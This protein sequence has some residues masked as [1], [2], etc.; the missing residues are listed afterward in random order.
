MALQPNSFNGQDKLQ[1]GAR[2]ETFQANLPGYRDQD[3][4]INRTNNKLATNAHDVPNV[5]YEF[6]RRLPVLFRYGFAYGYNQIVIPKGRLV[7]ADPNM[8][9]LDFDMRHANNTLTLANGG[10][11][12]RL[13]TTGDLYRGGDGASAL[14]STEKQGLAVLNADKDWIPLTGMTSAYSKISFK[15]FHTDG[16]TNQLKKAGYG[17]DA[18]TGKVVP[19][20][21]AADEIATGV[22]AVVAGANVTVR[23]GNVPLGVLSR[24][25][26]TRDDDAYNGMM[27]GA[28]MTDAMIDLPW[29]AYKDKA[30]QNPWG[31]AYGGLFPGA[32]IKSDEN[33]RFVVS[34]LSFEAEIS[35]M[36]ILE[37]ELERQQVIG[38]IYAV[39]NTLIPEGAAKWATWALSDRMNFEEF[40]P[41]VWA[42]NGRTGEDAVSN[43]PYKSSGEYP[44]YPYDNSITQNDLNML[45]SNRQ[46]S[47][48]MDPAYQYENLGI[49]GLTDGYNAV[50]R[51][52]PLETVGQINK[53]EAGVDY[54]DMYFR[55]GEVNVEALQIQIGAE[56]LVNCAVGAV[57][58]GGGVTVKYTDA[59]QGI[60]TLAVTDRAK[61]ETFLASATSVAVKLKYNKRGLAGV[62]TFLDWDGCVGSVKVLLTK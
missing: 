50:V 29:F 37:Y 5:K 58:A 11:P 41:A 28:V 60:I 49:P 44:G 47:N 38:Q 7:A 54:V 39:D 1:P 9:L 35:G 59:K 24:N 2:G 45:A 14:V 22:G 13:R 18:A 46:Y 56:A 23:V 8:D 27:P 34:P 30:E 26:Y 33:G 21:Y 57:I 51:D 62:P 32:L 52:I 43:S 4:R 16:P 20:A 15:P 40:N 25:E 61:F 31:S 48:R 19:Q 6:D 10:A 17:V 55:T 36:S 42:Q 3:D 53:A 12:V